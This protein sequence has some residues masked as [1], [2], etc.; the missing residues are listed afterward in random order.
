MIL[1]EPYSKELF[2]SFLKDFLPDYQKDERQVR[3]TD[4]SI[5]TEV[6]QLGTSRDVN[7]TVLEAKCE[8]TDTNKRIAITQAAFKVLRDHSIRNAI[9]AFHDGSDQWRLSL[10]TSTLDIKNG[11]VVKK[12]S[13]PRRYSYL[14]GV[15]AKT[16]TPYKYL[17][18]KGKIEDIKQLQE[19]FSVEVVNKQFYASIANLFTKLIGGER[20]ATKYLGLLKLNGVVN[21]NVEHQEFAVRL[22]GRVIF[23]WFLKEKKSTT[24]APIVPNELLSLD[25]VASNADYYHS[26]LEPLFFELL[27]KRIEQRHEYLR[28][29]PF[30]TVPYLNGGLFSPQYNDYY[31]QNSFNGAGTPGLTHIPDSWF[32]ELFT[33][34]EQYNFTV[35]ENTSYDV[36][37]SIDPEM[38]GRIFENLLA[39]INPETGESARKNTGSFYTPREIVDYMVD[40]SLLEFLKSKTG[41]EEEKLK[42]L[43]S[44]GQLDD[45][46]YPLTNVEKEKVVSALANLT[47]LDPACGS[48]AF[49]IGILQ[50][51]VYI[52]QQVDEKAELWLQNQLRTINSPELRRDIEEKYRNENYD[53][54]RKLGV[55]RESIFGVDIQTIATEIS[56]LRCFLTL[57]IEEDVDDSAQNRGIRPLPNLDFKF[58]TANSLIGLPESNKSG[59]LN[60]FEDTSHIDRLKNIRNRYFGADADER[61]RLQV[62]FKDLQLTMFKS[63]LASMGATSDLYNVLSDWNPFNH[64]KTEWFDSEWMFGVDNF[65]LVIANPPYVGEKGSKA[66]FDTLKPGNIG[67][68]FYKGKMDLF[69]FFFHLGLDCL[70]DGGALTFITTNYYP[71]ANGA[72]RLRKDFYERSNIVRLINFDE[73]TVFDS[74]R[75]QHNLITILQRANNPSTDYGTEEIVAS[76]KGSI[77]SGAL[78]NVLSGSSELVHV[79]EVKKQSVYDSVGDNF[80]I[81]FAGNS[82]GVDN[83]LD[84]VAS[85]GKRLDTFSYVNQGVISGADKFSNSHHKK[86]PQIEAA[87]GDGI[88]VFP[89]GEIKKISGDDELAKAWFKNSDISRYL[90]T[91]QTKEELLY[92]DGVSQPTPGTLSYLERFKPILKARR[93]FQDGNR[94]W[95]NLHRARASKIFE[96]EKIVAPQRSNRNTFGYNNIPWYASADVY[97]IAAKG[98]VPFEPFYLLGILNSKLIYT[99]LYHRGKRKGKMLE[100]YRTPLSEIPIASDTPE[101][102]SAIEKLVREIID[103]KTTNPQADTKDLESQIDQLVYEL[104]GL[105]P[106]EIAIV[107]K[108]AKV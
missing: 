8:E 104:Y 56:K 1:N 45:E 92:A 86:F 63:R 65:D 102:K 103:N 43:I 27:N 95:Y 108:S 6:T 107:E 46:Q 49:P 47:I 67:K 39:E 20:G 78:T 69:Y 72:I 25:A 58:V 91:V 82:G 68:R 83:I 10:L 94:P 24:G 73:I 19:R 55:I 14:L 99:W 96:H 18:E 44:W 48:G 12:D 62:E 87:K 3:T 41:A 84:K 13:N 35:D 40:S 106:E 28:E 66:I 42:A 9:I 101:Q 51:V 36:D 53:Y 54:L 85:A 15:G 100:L 23:S 52:L 98:G 97:L 2:D 7:V 33:V 31:N 61:A 16:V 88:F 64:D 21:Q 11:K 90:T 70:K 89:K 38:L 80:Y 93:E 17:I 4:K 75:G 32:T 50:K 37:L 59:K 74:A 22:I 79:C 29:I 76:S 105:N 57:V 77:S 26:A 34:L 71:T 5:L 30:S 60:L 81:R